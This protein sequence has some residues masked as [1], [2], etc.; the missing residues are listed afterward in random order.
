MPNTT[1]Y[2]TYMGNPTSALFRHRCILENEHADPGLTNPGL[3]HTR[4][5]LA[6][7]YMYIPTP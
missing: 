1:L 7:S 3:R 4:A 5:K 6:E 2:L